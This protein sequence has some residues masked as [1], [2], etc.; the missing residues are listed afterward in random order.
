MA[1]AKPKGKT[2]LE[3]FAEVADEHR[4]ERA[5]RAAQSV[6]ACSDI[7]LNGMHSA[8]VDTLTDIMHLA[9]REGVSFDDCLRSAFMHYETETELNGERCTELLANLSREQQK[10]F[11][12]DE[13]DEFFR[14]RDT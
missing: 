12:D 3:V 8:I 10:A 14:N 11:T 13:F 5:E 4:K 1:K 2:L 9:D 6:Q 7:E